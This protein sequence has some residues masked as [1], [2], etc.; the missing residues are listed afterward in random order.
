MT[1]LNGAALIE[2]AGAAPFAIAGSLRNA[3]AVGRFAAAALRLAIVDRVTIV[4]AGEQWKDN[5]LPDGRTRFAIED[6]LG[7]GAIALECHA[8]DAVLSAEAELAARAFASSR[9]D[10][11]ALVAAS[12]S[13]RELVDLGFA[14]DVALAAAVDADGGVPVLDPDGSLASSPFALRPATGADRPFLSE[15]ARAT[16]RESVVAAFGAWDERSQRRYFSPDIAHI[17][18]VVVDGNDVGMVEGRAEN[19]WWQL[20]NLR[21]APRVQGRGLGTAIVR[22]VAAAAHRRDHALVL[23]VLKVNA[24]AREFYERLGLR[25]SGELPWHWTME[26]S[27]P[28]R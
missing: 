4:A 17:A 25:V 9:S 2:A 27:P 7:A 21:L 13:G 5:A 3:G 15:L 19:G 8:G 26:L 24:R 28:A 20:A 23:R 12:L 18:V 6:W 11:H 14:P 10:L 22:F 16:M 1:S